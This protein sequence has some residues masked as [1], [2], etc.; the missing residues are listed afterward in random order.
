VRDRSNSSSLAGLADLLAR[1]GEPARELVRQQDSVM[2][3][4]FWYHTGNMAA[5]G[6]SFASKSSLSLAVAGI[7]V[8]DLKVWRDLLT[9]LNRSAVENK[10]HR[11]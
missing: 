4:G 9:A 10:E 11:E 1:A 6:S 5:C 3:F 7:I 8:M 2:E